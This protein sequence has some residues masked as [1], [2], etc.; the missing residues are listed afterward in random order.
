MK[1]ATVLVVAALAVLV[2]VVLMVS[3]NRRASGWGPGN[4][5]SDA[6]VRAEP[7]RYALDPRKT[8]KDEARALLEVAALE[9]LSEAF[10]SRQELPN[11]EGLAL[12]FGAEIERYV[13]GTA[14]DFLAH[15]DATERL[16]DEDRAL[17]RTQ[18]ENGSAVVSLAPMDDTGIV[19]RRSLVAGEPGERAAIGAERVDVTR[20]GAGGIGDPR[21]ERLDVVEIAVPM[22]IKPHGGKAGDGY[23]GLSFAISPATGQWTLV[24]LAVSRDGGEGDLVAPPF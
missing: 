21:A 14:D 19:V 15:L 2:L 18:W 24:G 17:F 3:M 22:R 16:S 4:A 10:P 1:R 20:R 6:E 8:G 12:T 23:F 5:P 11:P 9:R 13:F 7:R